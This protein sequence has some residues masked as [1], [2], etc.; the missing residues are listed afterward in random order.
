VDFNCDLGESFGAY[1]IG[2]DAE[3]MP[4][5]TSANVACGV[6]A[7]DPIVMERT[8]RLAREYG[9]G[10]GAHPGFPDLAGFGRREMRLSPDELR[11]T[12]VYQI[13]ALA[14]FARAQGTA[15][16]HVKGHGAL[17]NMAAYDEAQSRAIVGAI[18]SV[19]RNLIVVAFC[20]SVLERVAREAGLKVAREAYGD[21]GYT[22][23]GALV[24]R[25]HPRALLTDPD[26]VARRVVRIVTEGVVETVD[27]GEFRLEPDTLCFHGDTPGAPALARAAREALSRAGVELA[28]LGRWLS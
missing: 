26:A 7:G 19:D 27:D 2:A 1:T 5:V 20:G 8:V 10:I 17:Q 6:H 28:P 14:A 4:V 12:V 15:L 16:Q 11:T 13:G 24:S 25:S 9:V 18:A 3:M 21:R 22:R 23:T